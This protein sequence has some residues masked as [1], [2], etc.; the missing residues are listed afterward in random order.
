MYINAELIK[1]KRVA[2]S[3]TQQHLADACGISLRTVQRIERYG[4]ASNETV[5]A[6][7]AVFEIEQSEIV[8]PDVPVIEIE[9]GQP[10]TT[11]TQIPRV[12]LLL[13][14]LLGMMIGVVCMYFFRQY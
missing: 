8:S 9:T 14:F 5:M 10:I 4:N 6:L 7:A 3:W 2:Q 1:T 11:D 12:H 13:T